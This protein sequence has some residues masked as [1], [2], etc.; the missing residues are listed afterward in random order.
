MKEPLIKGFQDKYFYY[1][2]VDISESY[3]GWRAKAISDKDKYILKPEIRGFKVVSLDNAFA[4]FPNR[5]LDLSEMDTSNV[6]SMRG[7]FR[8]A[9]LEC[10][11]ISTFDMRNVNDCQGLFD[12]CDK[13][14]T[15]ILP[16][17]TIKHLVDADSMFSFCS[18]LKTIKNIENFHIN[19]IGDASLM[20]S[21]CSSLTAIDISAL[22]IE[23]ADY[24]A[25]AFY[26]AF[27]DAKYI[28]V[29]D[30]YTA[31]QIKEDSYMDKPCI[32]EGMPTD[33]EAALNKARLLGFM[34]IC[35]VK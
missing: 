12:G 29:N 8:K 11:D 19:K 30:K 14:E 26:N 33:I 9:A 16:S 10:I 20:F 7:T 18:N 34:S 2:W 17:V 15:I 13:L 32:I 5:K 21:K 35:I 3:R 23:T 22:N 25:N 1:Q 6:I 4:L 24:S 28:I 27:A 31:D